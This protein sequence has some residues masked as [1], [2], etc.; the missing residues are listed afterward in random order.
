[1][2][3]WLVPCE[4]YQPLYVELCISDILGSLPLILLQILFS[5]MVN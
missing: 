3:E 2:A 1:M 4:Q 5:L